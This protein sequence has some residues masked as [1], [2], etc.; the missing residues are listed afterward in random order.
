MT[1]GLTRRKATNFIAI[2]CSASVPDPITGRVTIDRWHRQRGF[3]MIGYHYV[4]KTDGA[5]EPGRD[6]DSIGAHVEGYNAN[7]IGICL[8]G[9]VNKLNVPTDNFTQAQ[10][11][12][13]LTLLKEL[14]TKHP[15]AVIQG[16]RD[17][18]NVAKACPSFDVRA[19]L[20]TVG[21]FK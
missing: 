17:F 6:A 5:I 13:L 4:I 14:R 9:G 11:V 2:H 7:S 19:W 3:L 15:L 8:V 20:K 18:P 16:H 21:N 1:P 12:S 10:M